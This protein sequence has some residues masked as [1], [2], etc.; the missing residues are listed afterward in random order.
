MKVGDCEYSDDVLYDPECGT[1]GRPEG[2]AWRIGVAP[3]LSWLSGG[4]S[5]V[6]LKPTG[7]MVS[8]GNSLGSVEGPRHFDVVRSPFDCV[9]VEAN[10]TVLE[11]PRAVNRDPFGEG[12]LAVVEK[13]GADSTLKPLAEAAATIEEKHRSMRVQCFAE[14]PD[15]ELFE[16]GA[17]CSAVLARL[18]E[19]LAK[20]PRGTVVHLVS[21]DPTAEVEM[22]RWQDQT[23]N[24]LLEV[25]PEGSLRHFIVKKR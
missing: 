17:E 25:R 22:Y 3:L 1:W 20:S 10:Q 9:V 16:V 23:G 4:F 2:S 15:A 6:S 14:F 21:D 24:A 8:L 18:D 12:W 11:D 19:R 7:T 13:A 5:V